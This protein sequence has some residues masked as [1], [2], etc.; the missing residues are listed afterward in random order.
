MDDRRC[1]IIAVG[2]EQKE[3]EGFSELL[4][5][6]T[7]AHGIPIMVGVSPASADPDV[8]DAIRVITQRGG[9]W[10]D[11]QT[12]NACQS[13]DQHE[14]EFASCNV[15]S[16]RS[17]RE[18]EAA[19]RELV[20]ANQALRST[21]EQLASANA[22]LQAS[23]EEI[24]RSNAA[25]SEANHNLENLLSSTR[26]ATVFLDEPRRGFDGLNDAAHGCRSAGGVL[27]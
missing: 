9:Q 4:D 24:C 14:R 26:I 2:I 18:L 23:S 3:L 8:R 16:V 27:I 11:G 25:L 22:E 17:I 19:N 20:S 6:L 13:S 12:V 7:D 1:L 5:R 15:D 10:F 21:N